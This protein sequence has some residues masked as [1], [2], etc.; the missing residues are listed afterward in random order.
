MIDLRTR[1]LALGF[2]L[3][4]LA[5]ADCSSTTL[6]N[7]RPDA[8]AD[9]GKGEPSA[10]AEEVGSPADSGSR[11]AQPEKATS[12][13]DG[14]APDVAETVGAS[15]DGPSICLGP[16]TFP[17]TLTPPS[18]CPGVVLKTAVVSFDPAD[19]R[20]SGDYQDCLASSGSPAYADACRKL[21]TD[22]VMTNATL[23]GS[24]GIASCSLDCSQPGSPVLSVEYS[25]T[26]CEPTQPDSGPPPGKPDA[27]PEAA[28]DAGSDGARPPGPDGPPDGNTAVDTVAIDASSHP[29]VVLRSVTAFADCMP[30]ISADPIMVLWTVDITGASGD[31]AQL[32]RATITVSSTT[33]I[34]QDFTVANPT[35]SLLAGAGSADQRKPVAVVSSNSACSEMC[36]GATY[37]LDLAYA[38]DGQSIPASQSGNFACA[39]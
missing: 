16:L 30:E 13:P 22:L 15:L 8:Q 12:G 32:T 28:P 34:V 21:C 10:Q 39:Y 9:S 29:Q 24:Q 31:S 2:I 33:A 23:R 6:L 7:A 25:D 3:P 26:I 1:V 37:R 14:G 36:R 18:M 20:W 19:A 27:G 17:S 38:I 35:I 11:D 5:L 4:M